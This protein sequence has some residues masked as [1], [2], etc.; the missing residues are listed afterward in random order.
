MHCADAIFTVRIP[1]KWKLHL[2]SMLVCPRELYSLRCD[3][4]IG[5]IG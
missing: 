4:E 3:E 5:I 2:F 1:A